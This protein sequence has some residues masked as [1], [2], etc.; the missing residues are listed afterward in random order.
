MSE[1]GEHRIDPAIAGALATAFQQWAA[2]QEAA[3]RTLRPF[4]DGGDLHANIV[5]AQLFASIGRVAEG[6]HYAERAVE[7]GASALANTYAQNLWN[8]PA[9]R[10][11]ALKFTEVAIN[12]GWPIDPMSWAV[13]V[14]QQGDV[15]TAIRL[16]DMTRY[17]GPGGRVSEWDDLLTE[18]RASVGKMRTQVADVSQAADASNAT[19]AEAGA[20]VERER[21]RVQELAEQVGAVVHNVTS[22]QLAKEYAAQAKKEDDSANAY[23]KAALWVAGV[24]AVLTLALAVVVFFGD[25]DVSTALGKA[26]LVI[27]LLGFAAYVGKLA[28]DHRRMA[29]HWRHVEL[30]LRTADPFIAP[31]DEG[32]RKAVLAALA[33]RLFP[34][35]SQD[36]QGRGPT[37]ITDPTTFLTELAAQ[38]DGARQPP[39]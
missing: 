17:P 8:D 29:W 13:Q 32:P 15:A 25:H 23:T 9:N 27:P 14:A 4:A 16:I 10:E 36:P 26:S 21:D 33:L 22:I 7:G 2:D 24:T 3:I 12:R 38:R 31:L 37:D 6:V 35:Q 18:A 30:Q 1:L 34:G 39:G 11:M 5:L 20:T 28:G 19:I